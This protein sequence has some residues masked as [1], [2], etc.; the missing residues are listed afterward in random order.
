[1]LRAPFSVL[2]RVCEGVLLRNARSVLFRWQVVLEEFT[3]AASV[4]PFVTDV[5]PSELS[6]AMTG[7]VKLSGG[8]FPD[9]YYEEEDTARGLSN[10]LVTDDMFHDYFSPLPQGPR[11]TTLRATRTKWK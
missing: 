9:V 1:M 4:T 6:F 5:S 8:G 7:V 10:K 11:P 3:Y 2:L